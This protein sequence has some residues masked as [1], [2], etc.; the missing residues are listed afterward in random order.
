MDVTI[1]HN[2]TCSKSR[3]TLDLLKEKGINPDVILYL[4]TPPMQEELASIIEKL[5][6]QPKQ[7]IRFK[8][9]LAK[10]LHISSTDARP[11]EEWLRI[12]AEYPILMERPIVT[13]GNQAAI[14][15]PPE[16]I[17]R[18]PGLLPPST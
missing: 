14:G 4:D 13:V 5:G 9:K 16:N 8:E 2:P 3:A 10:A 1:F 15:R 6:I 18:M 11:D 7:L 12:M 17:L